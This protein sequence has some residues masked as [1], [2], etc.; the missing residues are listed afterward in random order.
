MNV[1][2][3]TAMRSPDPSTQ[4]GAV[5]VSPDNLI[6]ATGYNGWV[7]GVSEFAPDDPR[8]NRPDKYYWM[9]HAERNAIDNC[10]RVGVKLDGCTLYST[11]MPCADCT[12]GIIQVGI[13]RVVVA[14]D[15]MV[16]FT[17]HMH[18]NQTWVQG[19]EASRDMFD[20]AGVKLDYWCGSA[21]FPSILLAGKLFHPPKPSPVEAVAKSTLKVTA[22]GTVVKPTD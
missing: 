7:R 15:V 4:V 22:V 18:D 2:Y 10:A 9:A 1:A 12:R 21:V 17:K 6:V 19:L 11:V 14:K 13:K 3:L 5:I 20:E 16:E 8:W